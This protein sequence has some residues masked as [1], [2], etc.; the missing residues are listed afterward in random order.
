MGNISVNSEDYY[1]DCLSDENRLTH[2]YNALGALNIIFA[3]TG[4]LMNIII[5]IVY[6]SKKS[7]NQYAMIIA[8]ALADLCVCA[9]LLPLEAVISLTNFDEVYFLPPSLMV[10]Q[11]AFWYAVTNLSVYVL[12]LMTIERFIVIR[13]PFHP[14][15][16]RT[17]IGGL[18][19]IVIV[20]MTT[21][22]Y[23][24]LILKRPL[25]QIYWFEMDK[26]LEIVGF[27]VNFILPSTANI[28]MY[29]Y[30]YWVAQSHRKRMNTR[31]KAS[32]QN[33]I[34]KM[35]IYNCVMVLFCVTWLPF[36]IFNISTFIDD[37]FFYTCAGDVVETLTAL[38]VSSNSV[39]NGFIYSSV[40]GTFRKKVKLI[41]KF[42]RNS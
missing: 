2:L 17:L 13:D 21:F 28:I 18:G 11:I 16:R 3:V 36:I 15:N 23:Y 19:L 39:L 5:I 34:P 4:T 31:I 40:S 29:Q 42:E 25:T 32:N 41:F 1:T 30:I 10:A 8:L 27:T 9:G 6:W 37:S 20:S 26:T 22:V 35:R 24:F 14:L 7:K 12:L 38:L 33:P